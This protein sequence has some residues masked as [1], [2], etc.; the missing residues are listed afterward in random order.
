MLNIGLYLTTVLIWGTTW[1]AIKLQLGDVA[2]QASI[3]YRFVLA[4]AVMFTVLVLARRLQK[5]ERQD[6]LF[7]LLQG[8][9]LFSFNFYCFYTATGYISSGL[10]SVIFSMATVMNVIN[11][12]IWFGKKPTA[13]NLGRICCGPV[14]HYAIVLAGDYR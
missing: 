13:R 1:I 11:N 6:H 9:C 5:L 8:F 4:G 3:I 12:R 14:G 2:V 7:C 10:A